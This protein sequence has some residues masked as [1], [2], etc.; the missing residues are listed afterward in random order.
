M[1]E[2]AREKV[3]KGNCAIASHC[4]S[5]RFLNGEVPDERQLEQE[6]GEVFLCRCSEL[7]ICGDIILEGMREE[8]KV[9]YKSGITVLGRNL[10][11][12]DIEDAMSGET[13]Q[14]CETA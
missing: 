8:I 1:N 14:C 12:T 4:I 5:I 11:V 7:L 9:A 13:E 6:T 2:H 10:S 3:M